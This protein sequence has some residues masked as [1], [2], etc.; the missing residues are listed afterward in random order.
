M[1]LHTL[2]TGQ[3]VRS[4]RGQFVGG[5]VAI[6]EHDSEFVFLALVDVL[7]HGP[8]A[9]ATAR[10]IEALIRSWQ[11]KH[12]LLG[13]LT[14]IHKQQVHGRGAVIGLC[15]I[16]PKSG[17]I[18]YVGVGNATCRMVGENSRHLLT[19]EGVVGQS[20]R[21]PSLEVATLAPGDL[22]LLHSDGVSSHFDLDDCPQLRIDSMSTSAKR[23]VMQFGRRHDDASCI[24]VRYA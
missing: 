19:R 15:T 5:D 22:L 3:Y 4:A 7:G 10:E 6:V 20:L 2:E 14:A 17:E 24:V 23:I 11:K 1:T 8:Q 12:D 16:E 13:L 9:N 21:T 18:R